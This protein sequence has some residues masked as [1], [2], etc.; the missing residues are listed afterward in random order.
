[1]KKLSQWLT[2]LENIHK[3]SIDL[4]LSR[5]Q[6]V[7]T[8]L[9]LSCDFIKFVV[10]G[11]NGK[12]STCSILESIF[13]AAGY[14][15][16]LYTSP[17][18]ISFNE[19]ARINGIPAHDSD[20][21]K[22]FEVVESIRDQIPLTYFEFTTL[23][24]LRLFSISKLDVAILEIGLG[25][26]LDAVNVI[27]AD[28]SI[29]TNI[30]IDHIEFLGNSREKIGWEKSHICRKGKP[31]ICGELIPPNL[32]LENIKL[33]GADLWLLGKDFSYT[34]NQ[35]QWNYIGK[36]QKRFSLSYPVLIGENQ[37]KNASLALA[38]L[39]STSL[40]FTVCQEAVQEGLL[41]TKIPGRFQVI[42]EE[43]LT[44]VLDVAHNPHAAAVLAKNLDDMGY[45]PRTYAI[46]GSL[47]S[48]DV[49]GMIECLHFLIDDWIC[50]GLPNSRGLSADAIAEKVRKVSSNL[51]ISPL[52]EIHN[53]PLSAFLFVK[54]KAQ[55]NE[56][57]LVFGSFFTISPILTLFT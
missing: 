9:D 23:A 39:E 5:I 2:Y 24:I 20:L 42:K 10:G 16:G 32:F 49:D 18:L 54:K 21:I 29:I 40:S 53:D 36:K 35:N 50:V 25:G 33:V 48:K 28:C 45:Y 1:M 15:T 17:H 47:N 11:T 38:A 3:N 7:L 37:L 43:G 55:F 41:K 8:K 51:K 31:I 30:G 12:G 26:R 6:T 27:D 14:S 52:I 34:R 13:L 44:I 4:D 46:I 22:Q 57:I 56:R 19:R